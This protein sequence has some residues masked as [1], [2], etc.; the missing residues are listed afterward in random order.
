MA[1]DTALLNI[2]LA[3]TTSERIKVGQV[4]DIDLLQEERKEI[5]M[6]LKRKG[7]YSFEQSY[8]AFSADTNKTEMTVKLDLKIAGPK[9][10]TPGGFVE[11][12]HPK[13]WIHDIYYYVGFDPQQ[14][15]VD[16]NYINTFDTLLINNIHF[17]HRGKLKI[18]PDLLAQS[19]HLEFDELYNQ[20]LVQQTYK[21]IGNLKQ[22]KY[23]SIEFYRINQ[24]RRS[25]LA[26]L[27]FQNNEINR[28][29]SIPKQYIDA[30][31]LL[32]FLKSQSTSFE[33]E[34]T[35]S[36]GDYGLAGNLL[37]QH[38]NVFRGAEILD[39]KLRGQYEVVSGID[40]TQT[41]KEIGIEA[42]IKSPQFFLP[43]KSTGFVKK[44]NPNSQITIAYSFQDRPEYKRDLINTSFG[45][46]WRGTETTKH[47]IKPLELNQIN[48]VLSPEFRQLIEGTFQE[49]SYETHAILNANYIFTYNNQSVRK[50]QDFTFLKFKFET[51]GL[52]L[53]KF[54]DFRYNNPESIASGDTIGN[55]T[56][57]DGI[58][59]AQY[60]LGDLDLRYTHILSPSNSLVYRFNFGIGV[61]YG[62][63][64]ALPS[65]KLFYAGGANGIR[66]WQVKT[67]GP[68]SYRDTSNSQFPNLTGDIKLE[69]NFEY[70]FKLFSIIE[71]AMFVDVG[72][73]WDLKESEIRPEAAFKFTSFMNEL[74]VS[75]GI[76]LR[77]NLSFF[78]FRADMGVKT[79]DPS[80]DSGKR[81]IPF[82]RGFEYNDLQFYLTI[83]YPF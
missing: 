48:A 24:E 70:R 14:S 22:F 64:H 32:T 9:V 18:K 13:Y 2:I 5:E 51:A 82:N 38:K 59:Y 75:T 43:F 17:L 35:S 16:P 83:G 71:G 4:F 80:L 6:L 33:I 45:Y 58:K 31:V 39:L 23:S 3:D 57:F 29:D 40:S 60:V 21:S 72:N 42:S 54:N 61:P 15:M 78:V 50:H 36:G 34:G 65:E 30:K 74:A 7:Y 77:A 28:E 41:A 56:L 37:Y 67:L 49:S 8:I 81:W 46:I 19:N 47:A 66:G 10:K 55:Y 26:S 79:R 11:T 44:Y 1:K 53:T 12:I 69:A 76:G 63:S 27:M 52:L 73:I 68:G 25:E 20:D 62:N